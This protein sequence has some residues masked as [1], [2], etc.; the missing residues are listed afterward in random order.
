MESP[1]HASLHSLFKEPVVSDVRF[2][3]VNRKS[4]GRNR[5]SLSW[6]EQ[7][8]PKAET[9]R[10]RYFWPKEHISAE[11]RYLGRNELF[12]SA[13]RGEFRPKLALSAEIFFWPKGQILPKCFGTYRNLK[14]RPKAEVEPF[15]LTTNAFK[16]VISY[17]AL[18]RLS[19]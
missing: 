7:F 6:K 10:K 12:I 2:L 19:H 14:F 13:G 17:P 5:K 1:W 16:C 18:G 11:R 9:Y 8:W 3:V 15:R 4:F